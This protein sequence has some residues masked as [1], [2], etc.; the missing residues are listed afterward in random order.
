MNLSPSLCFP[1]LPS[2]LSPAHQRQRHLIPPAAFLLREVSVFCKLA[3]IKRDEVSYSVVACVGTTNLSLLSLP[4]SLIH[5]LS[6]LSIYLFRQLLY[7]CLLLGRPS[8][9]PSS[10]SSYFT[11]YKATKNRS[12][13]LSLPHAHA[14]NHAY[15]HTSKKSPYLT[16]THTHTH[17]HSQT[18][19]P[20]S[21]NAFLLPAGAACSITG[22]KTVLLIPPTSGTSPFRVH[23][24]ALKLLPRSLCRLSC[25]CVCECEC[26]Y[27]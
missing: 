3:W 11:I 27:Q 2:H 9:F 25:V 12:L 15:T 17:I 19:A 20:L 22:D 7:V 14:C 8:S 23:R 1:R 18:L 5:L 10:S 13:T 21:Y 24:F 26:V 6:Y 4:W 16:H